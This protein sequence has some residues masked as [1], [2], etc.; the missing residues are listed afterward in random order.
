MARQRHLRN[1]PIRE[2]LIDIAVKTRPGVSLES[3][4]TLHESIKNE[5]PT[6][7][8]VRNAEVELNFARETNRLTNIPLG[9]VFRS[10][11][12]NRAVQFRLNGFT[13]NWLKPYAEWADLRGLAQRMWRI[14]A[15]AV[16]PENVVRLGLRYINN[17]NLPVPSKDFNEFMTM[18]PN[19]P[20]ALPQAIMSFFTRVTFQDPQIDCFAIV[21]QVSE[22][23]VKPEVF[24]LILDIDTAKITTLGPDSPQIWTSLDQLRD[25]KNLIFFESLTEEAV[26]IFE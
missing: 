4:A 20:P 11:D 1:A 6:R 17:L 2:A 12:N 14:Y 9:Y 5:F 10:S 24:Q 23:L 3:L 25:F 8:E 26:K 16:R 22:G 13:C 18:Q 19:L 7:Q 15:E 21:T